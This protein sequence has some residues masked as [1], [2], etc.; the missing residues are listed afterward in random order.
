VEIKYLMIRASHLDPLL[1]VLTDCRDGR[2]CT[3]E[4]LVKLGGNR[5]MITQLVVELQQCGLIE[6]SVLRTGKGRPKHM[7]RTT[8]L[9]EEFLSRYSELM[10]LPV[11]SNDNDLAKAI[12]QAEFARR[13]V[14]QNISPYARFQE[15]N[16]IVKHIA[17]TEQ[18]R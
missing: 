2:L 1:R 12:R 10:R 7:L 17:G 8:A 16:R 18:A 5:R 14:E 4:L 11:Q 6:K 3:S 15:V 13:L 9:G